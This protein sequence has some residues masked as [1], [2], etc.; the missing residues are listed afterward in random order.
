MQKKY[1]ISLGMLMCSATLSAQQFEFDGCQYKV[2]SAT[3]RTVQFTAPPSTNPTEF[4]MPDTVESGG[5]K[6]TVV[7]IGVNAFDPNTNLATITLPATLRD[8]QNGAFFKT[9]KL[10]QIYTNA[11]MP[12]DIEASPFASTIYT[13]GYLH[14]PAGTW[15]AYQT[16]WR[17]F[18]RIEEPDAWTVKVGDINYQVISPTSGL[19][20]VVG[21][22]TKYSGNVVIPNTVTTRGQECKVVSIGGY[23]FDGCSNLTSVQF[24]DS[25]IAIV[26]YAFRK[27]PRL[28]YVTVPSTV[29]LISEAAFSTCDSL[30]EVILPTAL[31]RIENV[32]FQ[33]CKQLPEITL[34]DSLEYIGPSAFSGCSSLVSA[35]GG[36][37]IRE[38]MSG[39]FNNC[40]SLTDFTMPPA[41]E[42]IGVTAFANVQVNFAAPFPST[43]RQIDGQ[44]FKGNKALKHVVIPDGCKQLSGSSQF[45]GC[46]A[47]ETVVL[48]KEVNTNA[49]TWSSMFSGCTSLKS[50]KLPDFMSTIPMNFLTNCSSLTDIVIPEGVITF[51][52]YSFRGT[53]SLRKINFP[54]T[55]TG[56]AIG[57][58]QESGLDSVTVP[59][60]VTQMGNQVFR[61]CPNLKHIRIEGPV[62]TLGNYFASKCPELEEVVLPATLTTIGRQGFADDPKLKTIQL[63]DSLNNL[64][65]EIFMGCTGLDTITLP[66]GMHKVP[67]S[68]FK[69]C[70]ALRAITFRSHIDTISATAFAGCT[71]LK[72]V[73][74]HRTVPPVLDVTAFDDTT[75]TTATLHA[76]T[77]EA[78]R[79]AEGWSKFNKVTTGINALQDNDQLEITVAPGMIGVPEGAEVY[80]MQGMRVKPERL[81]RGI[82]IVRTRTRTVKV[83]VP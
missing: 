75:Y 35:H 78:Y 36:A 81:P 34:P 6:Y 30:Q 51:G 29:R 1:L 49:S 80:N 20:A 59:A 77:P 53:K 57:A 16:S 17:R 13:N 14:V 79:V 2:L 5:V 19:A 43:L 47:L 70:T 66:A 45:T 42:F 4:T 82:Y 27:C 15:Y 37:K 32:V 24:P 38:I 67:V 46:T 71:G 21:G 39:A 28:K 63:P 52:N 62:A 69:G 40:T 10:R 60:H 72:N 58:F 41:I 12:P 9:T 50:V 61:S 68:M 31:K 55:L 11:V 25:L 18:Y 26:N 65:S 76:R 54:S 33:N 3:E 23:A 44:A 22:A 56:I 7:S 8:I 48:P 64:Y 73:Y 83:A 74:A